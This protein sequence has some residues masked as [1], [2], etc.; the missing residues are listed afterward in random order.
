MSGQNVR[1][2]GLTDLVS[3]LKGPAFRQ[4]NKELR[5]S[6]KVIATGMLPTVRSAVTKSRAPQAKAMA[7]T[8]RVHSD[9]VPV[10]VVGKVNP[11]FAGSKFRGGNTKRRRGAMALGVV[12]GP[13]GGRRDTTAHENY[14]RISRDRSWGP[15]GQAIRGPVT[16]DAETAYLK[17]YI[18]IL[19]AHGFDAKAR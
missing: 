13:L 18:A 2:E 9:R 17:A 14:Y 12:S 7:N 5:A 16:R 15:L 8:V 10:V 4:V 19:K 1:T 11:R 6:A 3:A